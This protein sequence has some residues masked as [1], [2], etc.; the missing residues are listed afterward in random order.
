M[1]TCIGPQLGLASQRQTIQSQH[2]SR[3]S[4]TSAALGLPHV[5]APSGSSRLLSGSHHVA[6]G[7][8]RPGSSDL[9]LRRFRENDT[10]F[11]VVKDIKVGAG[12]CLPAGACRNRR[13]LM[14][15]LP[16]W[17]LHKHLTMSIML[18]SCF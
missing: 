4:L 16:S 6:G 12:G 17:Q 2:G 11:D 18:E 8:R 10:E 15:R 3:S 13:L 5:S 14:P 7:S 1:A 9:Q